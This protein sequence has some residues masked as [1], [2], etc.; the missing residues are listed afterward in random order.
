VEERDIEAHMKAGS[1][2]SISHGTPE[3]ARYVVVTPVR[4]EEKHLPGTIASMVGQTCLP[5]EWVIVDDGSTDAT[6]EILAQA[7][8]RYPWI[9]AVTRPDRGFR[10]SGG[11]VVEA[12]NDGLARVR[13]DDWEFLV[14]LDGDLTFGP[15]YFEESLRRFQ[16]QPA[17]GIGGGVVVREEGG[18]LVVDSPGDPPFHVR[19]AVKMYRRAC[20]EQIA[21]LV[22]APGWDTI[23]E[24][25]AN[26]LGWRTRT[27]GGLPVIQHKPTGSAD[28]TWKNWFKNGR[29]N[30]VAGYHPLF[31]LAKCVARAVR[32]P[33]LVAGMGLFAG[34]LT[35]FFSFQSRLHDR[36]TVGYLRRQ[37]LRRLFMRP[38]IY[39]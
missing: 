19:G 26:R 8:G 30:Y 31:M 29:A 14:K 28:G 32:R 21:P 20:W 1:I 35:G 39:G 11:G 6:P 17:L 37:Q 33:F 18:K 27:F 16:A 3:P 12:F 25:K 22:A 5:L 38:S 4:N 9:T 10:K 15:D 23:D 7:A 2:A 24:V 34:Y 36:T 13:R